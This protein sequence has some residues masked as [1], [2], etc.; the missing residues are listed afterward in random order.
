[1]TG[2]SPDTEAALEG[3]T[4]VLF[5]ELGWRTINAYHKVYAELTAPAAPGSAYVGRSARSE[6]ILLL[7]RLVSGRLDVSDLPID[8]GGL[9]T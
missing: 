6:V 8:T 5:H 9:D 7:P 4:L 2:T 3:A 1:M